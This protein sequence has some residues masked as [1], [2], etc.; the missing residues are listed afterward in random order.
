MVLVLWE[1]LR[2]MKRKPKGFG[3]FKV[4]L[5]KVASVSK[6]IVEA[7]I[8]GEKKVINGESSDSLP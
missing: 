7:K 3:K 4:V 6:E 8:K 1:R 2:F 5:E